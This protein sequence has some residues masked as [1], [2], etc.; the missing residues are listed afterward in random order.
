MMIILTSLISTVSFGQIDD[1]MMKANWKT[2]KEK[3]IYGNTI[4][5]VEG[6]NDIRGITNIGYETFAQVKAGIEKDA[7]KEMWT[8]EKKNEKIASYSKFAS[9]GLIHLYLTRLTIDAANT[10]MFTIIVKDST[11]TE[12]F[13]KELKSDVP[14]VPSSGSNYWWNY[15]TIPI[16]ANIQG[17]IYVY[18]IDRLGNENS[19]FKFEIKL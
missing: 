15:T 2:E 3:V 18:V 16:T 7:E 5:R 12:I 1:N 10:N 13:R 8:E 14:N 17:K 19:K 4:L 6:K 11:E 9:G